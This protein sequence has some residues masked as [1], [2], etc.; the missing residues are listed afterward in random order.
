MI[1]AKTFINELNK[2]LRLEP[3]SKLISGGTDVSL[4]VTKERKDLNS[5]IYLN[6]IDELEPY[7][8]NSNSVLFSR[9]RLS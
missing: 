3:N 5:L 6:S 8:V 9:L 4:I 1:N 7:P 2:I